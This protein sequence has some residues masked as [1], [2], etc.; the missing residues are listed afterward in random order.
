[1]PTVKAL[2]RVDAGS[3]T[4]V[5]S[6]VR[7]TLAKGDQL[8]LGVGDNVQV[9]DRSLA[10]IIYRGGAAPVLCGGTSVSVD[11]LGSSHSRPIE[12]D[13]AVVLTAGQLLMDT[14]SRADARGVSFRTA[15]AG[16]A[17]RRVLQ[18]TNLLEVFRH[19]DSLDEAIAEIA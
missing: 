1:M 11:H 16:R 19:C 2:V 12:S 4:A 18:I 8:Y 9:S 5:V 10:R 7:Y 15:A 6:G 17:V 3:A 13:A 14:R